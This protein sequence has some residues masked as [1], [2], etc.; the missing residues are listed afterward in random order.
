MVELDDARDA[1]DALLEVADLLEVGAQLDQRRGPEAVGVDGQL[2][3]LEAVQVRLDQHQVGA[4]LDGQEASARH[5]D[6]VGVL[7]VPDGRAHG[8]LELDDGDVRLAL[9]VGGDGLVVGDDLHLE[10][11][12]LDDILDRLEVEPDVV[13]VEVLELLDRLELLRVLLGHLRDLQQ[14]HRVVVVDDGA[15]LDVRLG[16]VRQLHDVLRVPLDHVLQ[17]AQVHDGAEV[18][19]VGQEEDLHPALDQLVED[20]RVVQRLEDVAVPGRIPVRDGRD[21]VLGHGQHRVLEDPGVARLVE[22]QD[23][24]V[25]ALVLFDDVLRVVVRVEGVHQHKRH[26]DVVRAVQV[27]DLSHR[28]VQERHAVAHLDHRLGAHTPHGRAQ[29]PVELEHRQLAEVL[30]R[31][32]VGQRRVVHHLVLFGRGDAVPQQGIALGLVVEIPAEEGEEVVHL[33]LEQLLPSATAVQHTIGALP[34]S[35]RRLRPCRPGC[36]RRCA[37]GWLPPRSTCSRK[38][39]GIPWRSALGGH[40]SSSWQAS[41]STLSRATCKQRSTEG[42]VAIVVRL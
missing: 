28:Q 31:F 14:A 36:S 3:M 38:P 15:A 11:V 2:A 22:G 10:R 20:A 34:S 26:V 13:G 17:D 30:D 37:S 7:E 42:E 41:R 40:S 39:A 25:V 8:R 9:L 35:A 6:A 19:D 4:G 27:F 23:V 16:L 21:E 32:R 33:R 18:V 12:V 1:G 5:V 29:A 24:D